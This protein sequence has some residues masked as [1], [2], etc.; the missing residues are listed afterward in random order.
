MDTHRKLW[1]LLSFATF[2]CERAE[3]RYAFNDPITG[4]SLDLVG[5]TIDGWE[6]YTLAAEVEAGMLRGEGIGLAAIVRSPRRMIDIQSQDG[7]RVSIHLTDTDSDGLF[8]QLDYSVG[9]DVQVFDYNIDGLPDV[10]VLSGETTIRVGENWYPYESLVE[11]TGRRF[12]LIGAE[13]REVRLIDGR[14]ELV[15]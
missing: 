3:T 11:S 8:D 6:M 12:A 2:G 1:L 7:R 9:S 10:R 5:R 13:R 15:E 4:E 14:W